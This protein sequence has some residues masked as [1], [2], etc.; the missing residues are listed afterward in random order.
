MVSVMKDQFGNAITA[1]ELNLGN[2]VVLLDSNGFQNDGKI[3][4]KMNY[5][6]L[7]NKW[8]GFGWNSILCKWP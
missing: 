3:N 1:T 6:N 5:Q 4:N 8:K 2:L 7:L